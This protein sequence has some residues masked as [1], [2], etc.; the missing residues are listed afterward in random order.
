VRFGLPSFR[1]TAATWWSTVRVDRNSAWA[2]SAFAQ[3]VGEEGQ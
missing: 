1:R 2:I 3:P